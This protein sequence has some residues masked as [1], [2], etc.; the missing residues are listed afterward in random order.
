MD[1]V[2]NWA[3]FENFEK[4]GRAKNFVDI[5]GMVGLQNF[6]NQRGKNHMNSFDNLEYCL[7]LYFGRKIDFHLDPYD[8]KRNNCN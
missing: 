5:M 2:E 8:K 6:T 4:V 7:N 3:N 1:M